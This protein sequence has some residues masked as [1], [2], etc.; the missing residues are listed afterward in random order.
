MIKL[1]LD[2]GHY[3]PTVYDV[4]YTGNGDGF[5]SP[6]SF[7]YPDVADGEM[8]VIVLTQILAQPGSGV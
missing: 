5:H 6:R 7:Q 3:L 1:D 4:E 8:Q 2:V